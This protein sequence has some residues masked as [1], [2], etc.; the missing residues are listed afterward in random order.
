MSPLDS[1]WP[2]SHV[3]AIEHLPS[4][5]GPLHYFDHTSMSTNARK[6]QRRVLSPDFDIR[7]TKTHYFLEGELAGVQDKSAVKIEWASSRTLVIEGRMARP[8]LAEAWDED[9]AN[10]VALYRCPDCD[11]DER[12]ANGDLMVDDKTENTDGPKL[13]LDERKIGAYR[14]TFSFPVDV[15]ASAVRAKLRVGLLQIRVS[16]TPQAAVGRKR[17]QIE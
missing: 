1:V 17:V 3:T 12:L 15:D 6:V 8:N 5:K 11:Q 9:Q 7:E 16:K 2:A 10:G 13:L 4:S 14:R